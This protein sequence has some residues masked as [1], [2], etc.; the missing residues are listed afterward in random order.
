MFPSHAGRYSDFLLRN[1]VEKWK[2]HGVCSQREV[3]LNIGSVTNVITIGLWQMSLPLLSQL[4]PHEVGID[5]ESISM[6]GVSIS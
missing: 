5:I 1:G 3:T 4:S 2:L 6:V